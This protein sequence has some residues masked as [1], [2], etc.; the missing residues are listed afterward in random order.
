MNAPFV[1]NRGQVMGTDSTAQDDVRY[2]TR[3][4]YPNTYIFDDKVSFVFA[5]IDTVASSQD[6]MTRLD[7]NFVS[8]LSTVA[9]GLERQEDFHNYYLGH[10]PEGRERV[11]LENK[12][13]HPNIYTNIDAIY[14]QGQDG[15]FMRFVCKPG[16]SPGHIKMHFTGHTAVSVQTDGSLRVESA[17]EDLILAKPTAVFSDASGVESNASWDPE[18]VINLDGTVRISVSTVPSGSSLI[19]KTGR[20]RYDPNELPTWWSTYYG[21]TGRDTESAVECD[22]ESNVYTC[23]RSSSQNFPVGNTTLSA[24]GQSDWTVNKFDISGRPQWFVMIGAVDPA[25]FIEKA[26]DISVGGNDFLYVGGLAAS[27]W[28]NTL[29]RNPF[30]GF[31]DQTFNSSA[32]QARGAILRMNK[33]DGALQWGTFFGDGGLTFESIMGVEA[34]GNGGVAAVGYTW[35]EGSQNSTWVNTNPGGGALQQTFGDMYVGEFSAGD[36]LIWS[37][38][39]GPAAPEGNNANYPSD[40]A[41]DGNGNLF[42]VGQIDFDATPSNQDKFPTGGGLPIA[43][44]GDDGFVAKF[45]NARALTWSTYIGGSKPD[46]CAGVAI[47]PNTNEVIAFGTTSSTV[48]EGFP[49][50]GQG[51]GDDGSLNGPSDLFLAKFANN[52]TLLHSRYFGGDNREFT[53]DYLGHQGNGVFVMHNPCNGVAVGAGGN[54]YISGSAGDGLP[55]VWPFPPQWYFP[56]FSGGASDAFVAAFAS[57]FSLGYCTYLGSSKEDRGNAIAYTD[58]VGDVRPA[59]VMVGRTENFSNNYPTAKEFPDTYYNNSFLGGPFD[60]VITRISFNST[61]VATNEP[62]LPIGSVEISPNPAISTLIFSMDDNYVG[63]QGVLT[64]HD[65]QGKLLITQSYDFIQ[66]QASV[67][68]QHLPVGVYIATLSCDLGTWSGKFVKSID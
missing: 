25:D 53:D 51:A 65:I 18:F 11:P 49:I 15:F 58:I 3:S 35:Q 66:N 13:L 6:T 22:V 28:P 55:T 17:L 60:G 39:F 1:E 32:N 4:N 27:P 10:I 43:V 19:I 37:T 50:L 44:L 9:A 62:L 34:L 67:D 33:D 63:H 52:G 42:V 47:D 29:L 26:V 21:W 38:K 8:E 59:V 5:H 57:D 2:Y 68:I 20:G 16:S 56:N 12:V 41:A 24:Q 30:G 31:H 7:L 46:Y 45:S 40:I 14:G 48:G 36:Q 61:V 54:I 23:G 64:I